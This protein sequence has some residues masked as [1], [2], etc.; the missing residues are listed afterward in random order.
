MRIRILFFYW[1]I[2]ILKCF[3][4]CRE[5]QDNGKKNNPGL[6]VHL[7]NCLTNYADI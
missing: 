5:K 3:N 2:F 1:G 6:Y 4:G 7:L